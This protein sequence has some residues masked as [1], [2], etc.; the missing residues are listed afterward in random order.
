VS[1]VRSRP[2]WMTNHPP[3]VLWHCWVIRPVKTV[4]R[5]TYIV[6]VQTLHHA[7]QS[8]FTHTAQEDL[9]LAIPAVL[10]F[11]LL[12]L[13][14]DILTT[15]EALSS[16]HAGKSTVNID[17]SIVYASLPHGDVKGHV[18]LAASA[19]IIVQRSDNV[20]ALIHSFPLTIVR[21]SL[22]QRFV[23]WPLT[24]CCENRM[25]MDK[26]AA[27]NIWK[28]CTANLNFLSATF[29]LKVEA[30]TRRTDRRT[31]AVRNAASYKTWRN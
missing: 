30:G 27:R 21:R 1:L 25:S 31:C 28:L 2:V 6:L 18:T 26:C 15:E 23:V 16:V 4:G 5:I 12:L 19:A 24:Y 7:Q 11:Y 9:V 14:R 20:T 29:C 13:T 3:S 22:A 10:F 8:T 17:F